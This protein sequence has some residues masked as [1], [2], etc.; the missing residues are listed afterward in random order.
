MNA[1]SVY[2]Q[3]RD[4]IATGRMHPNER[5]VEA[6]LTSMFGAARAA[7]RT[8]LV[9]LE[10]E[11]IVERERNRGAKVRLVGEAE[12]VEIYETRAMLEG[13]SARKAA[14]RVTDE[15]AVELATLLRGISALLAA[16]DLMGASDRNIALHEKIMQVGGHKTASRLVATLNAYLVRFHYRTIMQ[17]D[18]PKHS[19]AE[20]SAIVEAITRRDPDAAE[21]AMRVHLANVTATL[22]EP[23]PGRLE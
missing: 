14:E 22:H 7:V 23:I 10:Q 5:L 9:R 4:A 15:E 3:L 8:A 11:G 18:R 19:F 20:H 12:A 16:N 2:E 13:L 6:D 21:T 17:P 1:D